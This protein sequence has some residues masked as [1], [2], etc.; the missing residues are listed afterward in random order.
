MAMAHIT[1]DKNQKLSRE[2]LKR[3]AALDKRAVDTSDI[4]DADLGEL[5]TIAR[6]TREKR[7]KK[8][9]SLR[10]AAETIEW[11]QGLGSGYTRVM[12][13]FLDEAKTHPEWVRQC[14]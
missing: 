14:L 1:R 9:F 13:K 4:P 6:L 12:A 11:W 5:K 7:K 3:L 8:M 2:A 10:L